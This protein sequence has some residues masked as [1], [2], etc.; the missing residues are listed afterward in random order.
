MR[1]EAKQLIKS[2]L[3]TWEKQASQFFDAAL[4]SPRVLEP[5]GIAMTGAMR[6]K[7]GLD[8]ALRRGWRAAGL[9]PRQDHERALHALNEIQ[10]KLLDLEEQLRERDPR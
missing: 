7:R 1:R 9:V 8:G 3:D 6:A 5:A 10:S 4:R 2:R